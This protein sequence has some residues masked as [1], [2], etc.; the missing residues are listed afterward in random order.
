MSASYSSLCLL[1]KKRKGNL[2]TLIL[3]L[4][5]FL[6]TPKASEKNTSLLMKNESQ[7]TNQLQLLRQ[8]MVQNTELRDRLSQIQSI[9]SGGEPKS[10]SVASHRTVTS[11]FRGNS[12]Q[13]FDSFMSLHSTISEKFF[14]AVEVSVCSPGLVLQVGLL[15]CVL[16]CVIQNPI[17]WFNILEMYPS[18]RWRQPKISYYNLSLSFLY[19][20][21]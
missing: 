12:L 10:H 6:P 21:N 14:D 17:Q 3:F 20:F 13:R 7:I 16:Y 1:I 18:Y 8:T 19:F 2:P 11:S 4:S 9:S 5:V 15:L